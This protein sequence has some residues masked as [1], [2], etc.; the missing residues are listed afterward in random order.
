MDWEKIF[1]N[2]AT[3]QRLISK[4]HKQ[5][6]HNKQTNQKVDRRFKQIYLQ[7]RHKAGQQAQEEMINITNYQRIKKNYK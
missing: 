2:G 6:N 4:I 1:A 5:L 7:R 3:N